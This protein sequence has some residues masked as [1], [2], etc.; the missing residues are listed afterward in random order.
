PVKLLPWGTGKIPSSWLGAPMRLSGEVVGVL[1]VQAY[2]PHAYT[3]ED[4]ALLTTIADQAAVAINNA[5]LYKS[6]VQRQQELSL[7]YEA[8]QL[9]MTTLN[10]QEILANT[11]E[12]LKTSLGFNTLSLLLVNEETGELEVQ[13]AIGFEPHETYKGEKLRLGRGIT[14]WVAQTGQPLLVPDVRQDERYITELPDIRSEMCVPIKA[15]NRVIGVID[16]ESTELNAFTEDQLRLVSTLAGHLGNVLEKASLYRQAK[17]RLSRIEALHE[18]D[19]AATSTLDLSQVLDVLLT[20]VGKRL[21]VDA[22]AIRLLDPTSGELSLAA[23]Q[24]LPDVLD[25]PLLPIEKGI[26]CRVIAEGQPVSISGLNQLD[27]ALV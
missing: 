15:S 6:A 13:A 12:L 4:M 11:G 27:R 8:A 25:V 16:V 22:C 19:L 2:W 26:A 1:S 21:G 3:S 5:A 23:G 10:I 24:G 18:I 14:G 20:Q 17:E 9:S 7:L